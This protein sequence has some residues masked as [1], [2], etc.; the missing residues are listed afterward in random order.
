[1]QHAE[2]DCRGCLPYLLVHSAG[3]VG[4][5]RFAALTRIAGQGERDRERDGG[6]KWGSV[7]REEVLHFNRPFIAQSDCMFA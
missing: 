7:G 2:D 4:P 6:T 5:K 1:M 3:F